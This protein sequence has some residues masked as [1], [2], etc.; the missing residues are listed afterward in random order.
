VNSPGA[1][2][3][4]TPDEAVSSVIYGPLRQAI[5]DFL[6]LHRLMADLAGLE[7]LVAWDRRWFHLRASIPAAA[8]FAA[9]MFAP[10]L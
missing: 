4:S 5:H 8:L 2:D 6:S 1:D 3:R 9:D 7:H 10:L